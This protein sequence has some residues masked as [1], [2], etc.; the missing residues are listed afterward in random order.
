MKDGLQRKR[1]MELHLAQHLITV[2]GH[3]LMFI[4]PPK[5]FC[6]LG[7]FQGYSCPCYDAKLTKSSKNAVK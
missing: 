3:M 6:G 1:P 5:L 7:R 4:S 2:G